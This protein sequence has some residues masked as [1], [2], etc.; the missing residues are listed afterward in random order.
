MYS[1]TLITQTPNENEMV[2]ASRGRNS[3]YLVLND[4]ENRVKGNSILFELPGGLTQR[5]SS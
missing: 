1:R 5:N 4:Q 2:G 3:S